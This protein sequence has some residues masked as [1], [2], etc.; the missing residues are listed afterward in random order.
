MGSTQPPTAA[1]LLVKKALLLLKRGQ[2][3]EA[4]SLAQKAAEIAPD[5]EEPW[6][7]LAATARSPR[8][9]IAYLERALEINP[10]S[11][12]ARAGMAWAA[13][14][15]RSAQNAAMVES[16]GA[17]AYRRP[18]PR[19]LAV[20]VVAL[21]LLAA[22][23][24]FSLLP[25]WAAWTSPRPAPLHANAVF[26]PTI[27]PTFTPTSTP[28]PTPTI[29]PSPTPTPT[30]T[31]TPTAT[32]TQTPSPTPRPTPTPTPPPKPLPSGITGLPPGV[33]MNDKWIDINLSRQRL[34]AYV[35]T[36]LVRQFLIS[37]GVAAHPTVL[38]TYHI[39]VK[40]V[41]TLMVG[42][43][44]YLPNV[45]YTMYF[46]RGYGIHGTYWHHN[47]GTPM[48]HGCIN[49]ETNDARWLF[50]WAPLGTVVNIH[51]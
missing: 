15:L 44:Y 29:T 7:L 3:S 6:L 40:Y 19:V 2:R 18:F 4:R 43:G 47:F 34:Y 42:P 41:S 5:W 46:Y 48:S 10:R 20:L 9:S 27:T 11:R 22:L 14:R 33:G 23:G 39:Y 12:R 50:Y 31:N 49:M 51:Y 45:P 28:T 37:S 30:F 17:L 35:G 36:R 16:E 26:K 8:A 1:R 32:P 13:K 24:L 38:G 21:V 25:A